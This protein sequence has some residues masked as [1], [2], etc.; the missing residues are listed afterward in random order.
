MFE[1]IKKELSM[2]LNKK[3][4]PVR[5]AGIITQIQENILKQLAHYKYLTIAQ[6]LELD[7]IGTTQYN[8]LWQQ[9]T[10]LRDRKKP[11]V[12]CNSFP[13]PNPRK[14]KVHSV[15]Y[16]NTTGKDTLINEM[17]YF[18]EDIRYKVGRHLT[19]TQYQHRLY[20]VDFQI[21]LDRW[22]D[23]NDLEIGFFWA[24]YDTTGSNRQA[25]SLKSKT[26]IELS[27]S[28]HFIPDGVYKIENDSR[29]SQLHLFELYNGKDT[30]YIIKKL[31]QH[32]EVMAFG[33]VHEHFNIP[34]EKPYKVII[35]CT[36]KSALEGIIKKALKDP[37]FAHF[38][39]HFICKDLESGAIGE[40]DFFK[41][42]V[43]LYGEETSFY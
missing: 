11:L 6:L 42:W 35:L 22:A 38:Y 1:G 19:V 5:W 7:G 23:K 13:N 28:K 27:K 31:Y 24:Y 14:G 25:K 10:S 41:G 3:N 29:E 17:N 33:Q 32:A 39:E 16:L 36:Y 18:E 4:K 30:K 8:Y 34:K 43:N 37:R 12:G 21:M 20:C 26:K 40:D 9:I 15:Y 2:T